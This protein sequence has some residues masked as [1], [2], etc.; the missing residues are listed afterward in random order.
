MKLAEARYDNAVTGCC[1]P[2]DRDRW[3]GKR[4]SW[5]HKRFVRGHIRSFLHVPVNFGAVMRRLHAGIEAA[6][7][8]PEEPLWISDELSPW[9]SD[10]YV[11]VDKDVPGEQ[12][13]QLS[14]TFLTKVFEGPYRHAGEWVEEMKA[15]VAGQG[16]QLDKIYFY[17]PTCPACAKKLGKTQTVLFARIR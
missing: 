13:S 1:A 12:M 8:Y 11:A 4:F 2:L 16:E 9:E 6:A 7:A 15:Y 17:Y 3:D 14:G 10:V 5:L